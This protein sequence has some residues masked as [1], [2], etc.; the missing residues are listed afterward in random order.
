MWDGEKYNR[1][2]ND[3]VLEKSAAGHNFRVF[4]DTNPNTP[5]NEKYKAVGGN[6]VH[7]KYPA[8]VD[9]KF[10]KTLEECELPNPCRPHKPRLCFKGEDNHP[11]HGNGLYVFSSEDGINWKTY[12]NKPIF[13][14]H[15]KTKTLPNTIAF[16]W[17]PSVVYDGENYRIFIRCNPKLGTRTCFTST[18]T[19]L[20]DWSIPE[21][22]KVSGFDMNKENFYYM[23]CHFIAGKYIAFAPHFIQEDRTYSDCYTAILVS[24]NG[25]NWE[26]KDRI[27]VS[28]TSGHLTFPHVVTVRQ[29]GDEYAFYV[30][31]NFLSQKNKLSRYVVDLK[32]FMSYVN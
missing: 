12:S 8:M 16:D 4:Y 3:V 30:H 5:D 13:S 6:S 28:K 7:S 17:M 2:K 11:R 23:D 25:I 14:Y 1:P 21:L 29:E 20:L 10:S 27:L 18:S 32:E 15:T 9:C 22:I 31:K 26:V 24:E 19:N